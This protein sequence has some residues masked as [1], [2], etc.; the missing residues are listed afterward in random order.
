MTLSGIR[1][2]QAG[3]NPSPA[4]YDPGCMAYVEH[5]LVLGKGKRPAWR[6]GHKQVDRVSTAQL[7]EADGLGAADE[8][9]ETIRDNCHSLLDLFQRAWEGKLGF[10]ARQQI[11]GG[12]GSHKLLIVL[13][14][15]GLEG[16]NDPD[17]D[18]LYHTLTALGQMN[19][20]KAANFDWEEY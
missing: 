2:P 7:R 11:S 8:S 10:A 20:L 19:V 5:A 4:A 15:E 1:L 18:T 13:H 14:D 12:S 3:S 6:A 9:V 16:P 17:A